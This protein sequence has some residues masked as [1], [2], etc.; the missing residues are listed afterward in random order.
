MIRFLTILLTTTAMLL[1]SI[2]G[3]CWHSGHMVEG[4]E[5]QSCGS[6]RIAG[7]AEVVTER[8]CGEEHDHEHESGHQGNDKIISPGV[9]EVVELVQECGHGKHEQEHS[10]CDH[11]RCLF[12]VT[13]NVPAP[14]LD[15]PLWG[16]PFSSV[17]QLLKV[18]DSS[19]L[20]T[21]PIDDSLPEPSTD[22]ALTS[23]WLV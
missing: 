19:S 14:I 5:V 18:A 8:S 3:C 12:V 6:E 2:L 23:V 1:H 4:C 16:V 11:G 17:E 22:R 9:V 7:Q 20:F 15:A 21:N 10:P 13:P